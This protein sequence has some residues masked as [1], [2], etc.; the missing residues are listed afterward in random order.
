MSATDIAETKLKSPVFIDLAITSVIE[1]KTMNNYSCRYFKT[2]ILHENTS[3]SFRNGFCANENYNI[4]WNFNTN[5][6]TLTQLLFNKL[7]RKLNYR[8]I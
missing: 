2:F 4:N 6:G 7:F 1:N 8:F 5:F 3:I